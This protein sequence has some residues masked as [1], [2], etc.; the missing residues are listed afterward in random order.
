MQQNADYAR[1]LWRE[2]PAGAEAQ[3]ILIWEGPPVAGAALIEAE[4]AFS[5][6]AIPGY[7]CRDGTLAR[8]MRM[9][10]Q[11]YDMAVSLNWDLAEPYPLWWDVISATWHFTQLTATLPVTPS[12]WR[13]RSLAATATGQ[14][15]RSSY[16]S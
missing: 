11:F 15:I 16:R 1:P 7:L 12:A 4:I 8:H 5:G 14:A 9:V 6:D 13:S 2:H 10:R 3:N